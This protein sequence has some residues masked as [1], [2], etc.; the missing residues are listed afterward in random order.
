MATR[1]L[2]AAACP[3]GSIDASSVRNSDPGAIASRCRSVAGRLTR[4]RN[5]VEFRTVARTP[6]SA[7]F[8]A[9]TL[10]AA[11]DAAMPYTCRSGSASCATFAAAASVCVFPHPAGPVRV[12][13]VCRL[14]S[15]AQIAAA[16]S[17]R[18]PVLVVSWLPASGL[19]SS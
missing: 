18:S 8:A 7:S 13:D 4:S 2:T 16:W 10:V 3:A 1:C 19:R 9:R 5:C 14:V 12:V 17:R 6:I 15:A 11:C